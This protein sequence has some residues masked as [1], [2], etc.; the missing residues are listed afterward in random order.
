MVDS[1]SHTCI[2]M[3]DISASGKQWQQDDANVDGNQN[4]RPNGTIM[5]YTNLKA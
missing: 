2:Y 1:Q 4:T 3:G 5:F